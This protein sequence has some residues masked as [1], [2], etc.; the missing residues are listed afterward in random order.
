MKRF[1]KLGSLMAGGALSVLTAQSADAA[2]TA[3][4]NVELNTT[5]TGMELRLST[6]GGDTPQIFAVSRDNVLQADITNAQL[7]LPSSKNYSKQNPDPAIKSI[8]V[9]ALDDNTVRLTIKGTDK[10]PIANLE[11]V[12]SEERRV[13]KECRSRWSPYH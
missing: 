7:A 12:R 4:Q 2:A 10:A 5:K 6:K 3:I 8:Q 9:E 1:F 11:K 13:G